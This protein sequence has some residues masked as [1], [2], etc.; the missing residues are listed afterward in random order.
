MPEVYIKFRNSYHSHTSRSNHVNLV[1]NVAD[2][3][4][5]RMTDFVSSCSGEDME[6]F[7]NSTFIGGM[8]EEE[9]EDFKHI[10]KIK[11]HPD[12]D[13]TENKNGYKINSNDEYEEENSDDWRKPFH[14][15][16]AQEYLDRNL[17]RNE[18]YEE[19]FANGYHYNDEDNEYGDAEDGYEDYKMEI[20]DTKNVK[21]N[22]NADDDDY[23][24]DDNW[25]Q[26]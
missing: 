8:S 7:I 1:G 11:L 12:R 3:N 9:L 10:F 14:H 13:E 18:K 20:Y 19:E 25:D 15:T 23:D 16:S 17:D 24:D 22:R 21:N 26:D 2:R 5:K 4:V 6:I